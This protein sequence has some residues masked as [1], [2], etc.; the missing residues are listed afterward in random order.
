MATS[1]QLG[2]IGS[3][4]LSAVAITTANVGVHY[5]SSGLLHVVGA[6]DK[7]VGIVLNTAA[8]SANVTFV[9]CK[10]RQYVA[11]DGG[12][13]AGDYVKWTTNGVL[14]PDGS[15]GSTTLSVNTVGQAVKTDDAIPG[16]DVEFF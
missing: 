6:G 4:T 14:T 15:T 10:G 1:D 7:A 9:R 13:A 3:G 2:P 5:D 11:T 16:C 12:V 8:L